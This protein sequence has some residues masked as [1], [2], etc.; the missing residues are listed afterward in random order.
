MTLIASLGAAIAG[1]SSWA[2]AKVAS[3]LAARK[4]RNSRR[5]AKRLFMTFAEYHGVRDGR[6]RPQSGPESNGKLKAAREPGPLL[7]VGASSGKSA[8]A[9]RSSPPTDGIPTVFEK[10][11]I[12][13]SNSDR[14]S[15]RG[16]LLRCGNR[17]PGLARGI[18]HANRGVCTRQPGQDVAGVGGPPGKD[19]G[20]ANLGPARRRLVNSRLSLQVA[21]D[22]PPRAECHRRVA[23]G[24]LCK[25]LILRDETIETKS[26][27]KLLKRWSHPPELNRRSADYEFPPPCLCY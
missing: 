9:G 22:G 12:A 2:L 17:M 4:R 3:G 7:P 26:S 23:M 20:L 19:R 8:Y 27:C 21:M 16:I 10:L 1:S 18:P 13:V 14:S 5:K 6:Q 24:V 15:P 11:V 25:L